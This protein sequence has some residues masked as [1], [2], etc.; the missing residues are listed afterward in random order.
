[1]SNFIVPPSIFTDGADV[2][3]TG[4]LAGEFPDGRTTVNG[5]PTSASVKAFYVLESGDWQLAGQ[6]TSNPDGTWL[7]GGINHDL[8]FSVVGQLDGYNDVVMANIKPMR[9][10]M[11]TYEGELVPNEEFDG[12]AGFITLLDG[13]PPFTVQGVSNVPAGLT[14]SVIDRRELIIDGAT[15]EGGEWEAEITVQDANSNTV[16]IPVVIP[17]GFDAP[18]SLAATY[19]EAENEITLTWTSNS[20]V[21]Q[22]F[23]IYRSDSP[24]DLGDLPPPIGSV[25]K[26][27]TEFVDG[28]VV[29]EEVYYYAVTA[30]RGS[31]VRV[32]GW[33]RTAADDSD[34]HW[35]NVVSLLHFDG[36][37]TDETGRVWINSGVTTDN[38]NS[39]YNDYGVFSGSSKMTATIPALG[40]NDFTIEAWV[41]RDADTDYRCIFDSRASSPWSKNGLAIYTSSLLTGNVPVIWEGTQILKGSIKITES[42]WVHIAIVRESG[43]IYYY[44]NGSLIGSGSFTSDL[45]NT[46]AVIGNTFQNVQAYRGRMDELRITKGVARYTENFDPPTGPFPDK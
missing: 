29:Y 7:I 3:G 4:F 18:S 41:N 8:R 17:I 13:M 36:D 28:T 30:V 38:T 33:L 43:I 22:A 14:A 44:A 6:A 1:M 9:T 35:D 24:L 34:P 16:S 21:E 26:G 31:S 23:Y 20:H 27:V 15:D 46:T 45:T 25:G 32:S 37:L 5:V 10:D 19:D 40:T 2:S 42:A 39:L 11:V 12:M